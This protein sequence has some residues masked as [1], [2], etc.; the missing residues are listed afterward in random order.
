MEYLNERCCFFQFNSKTLFK[1]GD[2]VSFKTY[3]PWGHVTQ[4]DMSFSGKMKSYVSNS[5]YN[6]WCLSDVVIFFIKLHI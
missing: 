4:L 6:V 2:P 3:L 1:D 5:I